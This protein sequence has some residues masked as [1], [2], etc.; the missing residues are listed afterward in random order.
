MEID[1]DPSPPTISN[2]ILDDYIK[3]TYKLTI[4]ALILTI[5]SPPP[6]SSSSPSQQPSSSSPPLPKWNTEDLKSFFSLF[7]KL[8]HLETP[9]PT[10]AFILFTTFIE[11]FTAKEYLSSLSTTSS[12]FTIQWYT[13]SQENL[14][15]SILKQKTKQTSS[16]GT[17]IENINSVMLNPETKL[18]HAQIID[19]NDNDN[20]QYY[21]LSLSHKN[22]NK[23]NFITNTETQ[24]CFYSD[25]ALAPKARNEFKNLM[26]NN[27]RRNDFHGGY[28]YMNNQGISESEGVIVEKSVPNGKLLC[29]FFVQIE[30]ES[31]FQISKRICGAKGCNIKKIVDFCSKGPNGKYLNDSVKIRL[32]GKGSGYKE[33]PYNRESE[34]PLH[35]CVSSK[36]L[37][38]YRK[39]CWFVQEL[40]INIY[41]EYKRYCERNGKKPLVNLTIQKIENISTKK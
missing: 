33:G 35:L 9:S 27:Q 38:K 20:E 8:L 10:T 29:K 18:P 23:E 31:G 7:G 26:L 21:P 28:Y 19:D 15:L 22:K 13:P 34:E 25:C 11:A 40:L 3:E 32:R 14:I 2:D 5:T 12:S 39:A 17:L 36:Y 4:P 37:E 6:P 41:E 24:Y 16:P 1:T 30:N